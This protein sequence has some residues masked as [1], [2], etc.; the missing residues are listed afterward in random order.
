M[1]EL[2]YSPR[3]GAH[4]WPSMPG[5]SVAWR[6]SYDHVH[7]CWLRE[8]HGGDDICA[9]DAVFER[10]TPAGNQHVWAGKDDGICVCGAHV[11]RT[12]SGSE[13]D[14]MTKPH[15]TQIHE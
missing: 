5:C 10:C 14:Y 13:P 12:F 3:C 11:V 2:D 6:D 1:S 9:C 7:A 15:N 8:G 4:A